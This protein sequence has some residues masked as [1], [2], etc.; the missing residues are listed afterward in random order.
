MQVNVY[1]ESQQRFRATARG[2]QIWADQPFSQ[3]GQDSG[4]TAAEWFLAALG[5]C[6]GHSAV[7]YLHQHGLS[8]QGL[9][10]SLAADTS[11]D[12]KAH[13]WQIAT[14][15]VHLVMTQS[16]TGAQRR[17]LKAALEDCYLMRILQ[18]P[19]RIITEVLTALSRT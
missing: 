15:R 16:L 19:P 3:G 17:S 11:P 10:L 7:T 1:Y 12:P 4:M 18:Q 8:S 5:S 14:V 13:D 2:H 6:M 9:Q